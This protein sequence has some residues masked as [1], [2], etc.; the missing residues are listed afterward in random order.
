MYGS[1]FYEFSSL[2]ISKK[3][4]SGNFPNLKNPKH[5]KDLRAGRLDLGK[6]IGLQ[7]PDPKRCNA[8]VKS[9]KL[10]FP[11]YFTPQQLVNIGVRTKKL[12]KP[13]GF[14]QQVAATCS[15]PFQIHLVFRLHLNGGPY[16][17]NSTQDCIEMLLHILGPGVGIISDGQNSASLGC[18]L[19]GPEHLYP[20]AA[21]LWLIARRYCV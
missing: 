4:K 12:N 11:G 6:N 9:K 1:R 20:V 18:P 3:S 10:L 21:T 5:R 19:T 16:D 2:E 17:L 8:S 13:F 7:T 15:H 14:A